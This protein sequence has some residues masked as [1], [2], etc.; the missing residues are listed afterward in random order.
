MTLNALFDFLVVGSLII[1]IIFWILFGIITMRKIDK[2]VV[3]EGK[4]RP[5]QWDPFWGRAFFMRGQ[6]PCPLKITV[7]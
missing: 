6:C 1:M 4:P 7:N 5:C 2:A 3:A